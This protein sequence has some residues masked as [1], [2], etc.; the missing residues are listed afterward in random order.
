MSSHIVYFHPCVMKRLAVTCI[1]TLTVCIKRSL[2][3]KIPRVV[4]IIAKQSTVLLI[5]SS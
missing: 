2:K 3:D 1:G 5:K 4:I